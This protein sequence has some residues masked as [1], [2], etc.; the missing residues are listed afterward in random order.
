[1]PTTAETKTWVEMTPGE[2]QSARF[3]DWLAAEGI[4]FDSPEAEAT[5]KAGVTRFRDVIELKKAPDRVPII[6]NC[7]FMPADLYGVDPY[8]LMYDT[9]V[10]MDTF[11]RFLVDYRP[12][13]YFTPLIIGSGKVLEILDCKQVAWPGHGVPKNQGYQYVEGEYMRDEEYRA[14]IDD[15]TDFWLRGYMPRA[16][17]ALEPLSR[18]SAFTDLWEVVLVTGQMIPFGVPDVQA[19]LTTLLEAGRE[20]LAYIEQ[21]GPFEA[22]ARGMGF[23]SAAGGISKA[24]FDILADTLR[25]TRSTMIDMHRRPELV[26]EAIE[27]LTPLAIKQGVNGA[28]SQA[29]PLVFMPL[30]KGADGFMSD[31]QFRT[32]YWPSLKAV[33]LGLIEEGCVPYLF[34]EGGYESRLEYLAE[35]PPGTTFC[36]F[37]HTNMARAKEVLRDKVCI[38]GNVPASLILTGTPDEVKAY[39]KELI[40]TVGPG[41][42]YVM[43]FGT[44]MDEGKPDTV[45]AM[46][47]ATHEY[48]VY[49]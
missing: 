7:T 31:E 49:G 42:G 10:L 28:T 27:R 13:Y 11:R 41:G 5:Y 4:T 38:G 17:G 44:A 9:K 29:N 40:E 32:F 34:C 36:H 15:P 45:H 37:D 23:V 1:M 30:H 16:F 3:E 25:G 6:L 46:V 26:L 12:D 8:D 22:E 19:A 21:V 33:C 39:C 48:G 35:L 14:L 20:A 43:A 18:I 47:E 24:P 2:R